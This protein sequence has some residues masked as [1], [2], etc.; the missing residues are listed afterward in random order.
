MTDKNYRGDVEEDG[1]TFQEM[2]DAYEFDARR[3]RPGE[4]IDAKIVKITD[5]WIFIDLSEKSEGYIDRT[6][7]T[8]EE[9]NLSVMEG[10]TIT[11]YFLSSKNSEKLFTTKLG[12]TPMAGDHLE[13]AFKNEIPV[14]G[15]IEKEVKGGFEVKIAGSFRAFCP[16]SQT[17]IDK[18]ETGADYVGRRL[19]FAIIEFGD[20]GR[21]VVLSRRPIIEAEKKKEKEAL[22]EILYEGMMVEGNVASIRNF[23]AFI[24]LGALQGL[25]PVSEIGWGR[26]D[27]INEILSVGEQIAVKIIAIDWERER[28]SLSLKATMPDPWE[29]VEKKYPEGS[30]HSGEIVRLTKFGAFVMLEPGIDGLVHISQIGKG[31]KIKHPSDVLELKQAVSV[32]VERVDREHKRISLRFSDQHTTTTTEEELKEQFSTYRDNT[33]TSMGTLGDI[34]KSKLSKK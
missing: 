6:E 19:Q 13:E 25:L 26:V 7:L 9:G 34:L 33:T 28:I 32:V 2:M 14:E 18:N 5:E 31:K 24:D 8:D 15:T 16:Y 4:K 11:V 12:N 27:D 22:K 10:D 21:N 20:K 17:C 1:I 3:L 30:V 23:G 29:E